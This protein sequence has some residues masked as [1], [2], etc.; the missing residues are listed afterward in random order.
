MDFLQKNWQILALKYTDDTHLVAVYWKELLSLYTEAN[1]YYHNLQHIESLLQQAQ[2]CEEYIQDF[3][4]L[5][6]AIYYHDAIYDIQKSDNESQSAEL[7]H[8]R[9][10]NFELE[11]A[12][13]ERCKQLI[14]ATKNH[15]LNSEQDINYM[16]DF[17]LSILGA[18]REAYTEY[19]SQ[20]RKEYNF[21]PNELYIPGRKKVLEYFLQQQRIYKTDLY[22]ER[23]E[24]QARE[25]LA[26]ELADLKQ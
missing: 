11:V 21:Y 1:R 13:L 15:L 2:A 26:K 5:C 6:F 9:L 20:I 24:A 23:Y 25:N 14:L 19:A 22:F 3:D 16:L 7:A 10:C 18:S 4:L 8:D 12:R 17:D